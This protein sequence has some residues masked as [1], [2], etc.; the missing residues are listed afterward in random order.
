MSISV[1]QTFVV[2][3][4]TALEMGDIEM[5]RSQTSMIPLQ[6]SDEVSKNE[7]EAGLES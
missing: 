2:E 7:E 3:M 1:P 4:E 6:P 5:L